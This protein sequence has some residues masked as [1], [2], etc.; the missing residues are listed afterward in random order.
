M[1]WYWMQGTRK[2]RHCH[3]CRWNGKQKGQDYALL[4][5]MHPEG[6]QRQTPKILYHRPGTRPN[7]PRISLPLPLQPSRRLDS[8]ENTRSPYSATKPLLQVHTVHHPTNADGSYPKPWKAKRGTSPICTMNQC[9][10]TVGTGSGKR[11]SSPHP[12][13]NPRGIQTTH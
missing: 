1:T 2:T 12:R 3:K 10:S 7:H 9:S 6:N 8:W 5:A 4:L 11:K 13:N